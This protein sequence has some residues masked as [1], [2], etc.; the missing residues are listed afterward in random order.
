M[1]AKEYLSQYYWVKKDIESMQREIEHLE[2]MAEYSSPRWVGGSNSGNDKSDKVGN[3]AVKIA[4][5]QR[6][7]DCLIERSL[8][9]LDEIEA[10]ISR[11]EDSRYRYI[12]TERYIN[13]RK[14]ESIADD[15]HTDLRWVHRLHGRALKEIDH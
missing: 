13:C 2:V 12:L 3:I 5:K 6:E 11:V 14:W 8:D 4:D 9:L 10:C 1:T 15:L 7:L